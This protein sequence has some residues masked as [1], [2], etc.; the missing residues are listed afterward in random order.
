MP[1]ITLDT[2]LAEIVG[3]KTATEIESAFGLVTARDLLHHFPRR[4]TKRGELTPL[5]GLPLGEQATV[6]AQVLRVTE[7]R[8]QA[9]RGSIIEAEITDGTGILSLTWFNQP[10]RAKDLAVGQRGVFAGK[11]GQ[12]RGKLQLAHPDYRMFEADADVPGDEAL[13]AAAVK[14][15]AET[16]EPIYP[17]TARVKSWHL[18][19]AI[20][21]VLDALPSIEEP[22]PAELLAAAGA[23]E[24]RGSAEPLLGF[25]DALQ[26]I[27]RPQNESQISSARRSLQFR[28]AFDLQ[29]ALL[30]RKRR[31]AHENTRSRPEHPDGLVALL[32]SAL[33]FAL[34][35]DQQTVGAEIATDL[36]AQRPMHRLLQGEVGSGKTLIALRAMLQ[37]A[38]SGGQ[39]ALLAP[40]EVLAAQH[41]RSIVEMLGPELADQMSPV[42]I[43]GQLSTAERK[44]ALLDVA[45]GAARIVVGTHALMSE[46]TTF[47]DLGLIVIDEQHRFGVEQREAL[48]RKGGAPPHVLV[49]TA[50]PIPRTVALT[51]FGDLDVSTIRELPPGRPPIETHS[52]PILEHPTWGERTWQRAGEEIAAGRQV[53]VVCP[54]ISP[55]IAEDDAAGEESAADDE[56]E[57]EVAAP[58]ANVEETLAELRLHP[59]LSRYRAEALTGALSAEEKERTMTAFARGEID[60]LVAT[61]VI[62]VGVNVPNAS[63]M[64]VRDAERFGISQLH[65]LRGRVGRGSQPGLCLLLTRAEPE[66]DA[67]ARIEAVAATRDG[68]ALAE[69]D[70]ELRNEGDILGVAQ[71]GGRSSLRLLRVMRD[72]DVLEH[73]RSLAQ[74]LLERDPELR[75][76]PLLARQLAEQWERIENL[77]KS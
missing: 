3:G 34:T 42:L 67:R 23:A 8:M 33:S 44:R 50:T 15:W 6:V 48:R 45:A 30:D 36:S 37:V 22:L 69:I 10:W 55:S 72:R 2:R 40:T 63:L 52:V 26:R 74:S 53:Y 28:E 64:I 17:A 32:D 29:L 31:A 43:T 54:A 57:A 7:R 49:M 62:E 46:T 58:I 16:P 51:A 5:T 68:F 20:G 41:L 24:E 18:A 71:S 59:A 14:A 35:G 47:F 38:E 76:A 66:S 75:S 39:S 13:R 73:A 70:V 12:Y 27:H 21:L 61:T 25:H 56:R 60:I 77:R 9:K 4:Y 65:Q 11:V 19:D 1:D